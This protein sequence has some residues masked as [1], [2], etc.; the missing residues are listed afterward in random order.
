[1][2]LA[3]KVPSLHGEMDGLVVYAFI[4][5]DLSQ[6]EQVAALISDVKH[7]RGV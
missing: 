4:H 5:S 6:V 7:A 3:Q 1:M 2:L